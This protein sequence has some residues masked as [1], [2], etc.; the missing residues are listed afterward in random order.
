MW[1]STPRSGRRVAGRLRPGHLVVVLAI[2][3][4]L[5]AGCSDDPKRSERSADSD[6]TTTSAADA[7]SSTIE[8]VDTAVSGT[9]NGTGSSFQDAFQQKARTE[10]AKTAPDLT[11][12]YTK[13][14]SAAGKQD[15]ADNVVQFAGT[16][17]PIAADAT[18][19]FKG[20]EVLYFPVVAAPITIAYNLDG[21]DDLQLSAD[22]VAGIF[23]GTI[24]KWDDDAI[25]EDNRTLDLPS[26]DIVV[27][28]RS[29]GSGTTANFTRWLAASSAEWELGSGDTVQWPT[30]TQGAE[31]SSGVA[32]L[33]STTKG[34]IGY[35][36]LADAVTANL[37]FAK[38]QNAAGKY[39]E[40]T[41]D[42][43]SAALEGA[44]LEVNLTFDP[45]NAPGD[46]AYPVTA[47]TWVVVYK[48]QPDPK[49]AAALK[50]YLTFLLTN[51]QDFAQSVGYARLP[52]VM[53][54]A[55]LAQIKQIAG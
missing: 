26:T 55:A 23:Q 21:I 52:K 5:S 7:T 1:R 53:L 27:I 2:V 32:T 20:G 38:I 41:L 3:G 47:P 22:T 24:T 33:V 14:G 54:D 49:V 18:G 44:A 12:N 25:E 15:L 13:S 11:V 31:K 45:I 34:S 29:D 36:D 8:P 43:A 48:N 46:T 40:A 9:L 51:G 35:V 37:H 17:S 16:D 39:I 10:F 19:S 50:S 30:S 4:L 6:R 42:A 28:R